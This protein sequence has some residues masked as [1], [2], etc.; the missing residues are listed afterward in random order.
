[1]EASHSIILSQRNF[2]FI[3]FLNGILSSTA[4]NQKSI[5][6]TPSL[7]TFNYRLSRA[8][9]SIERAFGALKNGFRLLHQ[10]KK[11]RKEI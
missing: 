10:N 11:K 2:S 4:G 3:I 6:I 9:C 1:M 8:R 5:I 7:A